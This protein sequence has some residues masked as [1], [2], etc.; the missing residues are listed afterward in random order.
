MNWKAKGTRGG[1]PA[2]LTIIGGANDE[3]GLRADLKGTHPDFELQSAAPLDASTT[4]PEPIA[5][6]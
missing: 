6:E 2:E 5:V 3:P 4:P 1:K